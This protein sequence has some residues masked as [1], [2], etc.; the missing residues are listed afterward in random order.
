LCLNYS[1]KVEVK[2]VH[3]NGFTTASK[4]GIVLEGCTDIDIHDNT[5][6]GNDRGIAAIYDGGT[7]TGNTRLN[8]HNNLANGNVNANIRVCDTTYSQITHNQAGNSSYGVIATTESAATDSIDIVGNDVSGNTNPITIGASVTNANVGYNP[9]DSILTPRRTFLD[10][11]KLLTSQVRMIPLG[12]AN[13]ATSAAGGGAVT[14]SVTGLK[15]T[16]TNASGSAIYY[17]GLTHMRPSA[18]GSAG[19][20]DNLLINWDKRL[21]IVFDISR[22]VVDANNATWARLQIKAATTEGILGAAGIGLYIGGTTSAMDVYLESY[23]DAREVSGASLKTLLNQ[24]PYRF[25][26]YFDPGVGLY[27]YEIANTGYTL[28]GSL[29][30]T[31]DLP[32]GESAAVNYL[33]FSLKTDAGAAAGVYIGRLS[34]FLLFQGM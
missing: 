28:L 3:A 7:E 27:L 2:G 13:W 11:A 12:T 23:N 5:V 10:V 29:V 18:E 22:E 24:V 14:T 4:C 21:A 8:I 6:W 19:G 1:R 15:T 17:A 32:S 26:L 25:C 34:N 33:M 20:G 31:A 9:G 16:V 30:D